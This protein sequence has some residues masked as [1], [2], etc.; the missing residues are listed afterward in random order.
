MRLMLLK[1]ASPLCELHEDYTLN[2]VALSVK[3][4]LWPSLG[5]F[6]PIPGWWPS[7]VTVREKAKT[8]VLFFTVKT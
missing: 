1:A 2:T 3:S 4:N 8:F 5:P 6:L 7:R